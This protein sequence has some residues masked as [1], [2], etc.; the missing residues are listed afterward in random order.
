MKQKERTYHFIAIGLLILLLLCF[1]TDNQ[2]SKAQTREIIDSLHAELDKPLH[3][4]SRVI[5]LNRLAYFYRNTEPEKTKAFA[6]RAL[7]LSRD[8][9]FISGIGESYRMLGLYYK[10][11][12]N[13][14]KGLEYYLKAISEFEKANDKKGLAEALNNIGNI[15]K[16][17][18]NYPKALDYFNRSLDI[19]VELQDMRGIGIS[20]NNLGI[21]AVLQNDLD[22]AM[23][24]YQKSLNIFKKLK[25]KYRIGRLTYFIGEIYLKQKNYKKALEYF[26]NALKIRQEVND[27]NGIAVCYNRIGLI[28]L[29]T[30]EYEKAGKMLYLSHKLA[31]EIQARQIQVENY[32][33]LSKLDSAKGDFASALQYYKRYNALKDS[34]YS[35]E[36]KREIDRIEAQH[37]IEKRDNEIELQKENL[38]SQKLQQRYLIIGILLVF[39]LL[40]IAVLGYRQKKKANQ[41][42][43]DKNEEINQQKEEIRAQAEHL[44]EANE[45]ITAQNTEIT[46]QKEEILVQTERLRNINEELET[47]S[48]VVSKTDN[49]VLITDN[50]GKIEW[51]NDSFTKLFGY[52]LEQLVTEKN[53]NIINQNTPQYVKEKIQY[54]I[55]HKKMVQYELNV[56]TKEGEDLWVQVTLTPIYEGDQLEKLVAID[57][58]ITKLKQAEARNQKQ[59]E[60]IEQQRD[61]LVKQ[62]DKYEKQKR[63]AIR[64]RDELIQQRNEILDSIVYARRIQQAVL[65]PEEIFS[66]IFTES[67]ILYKPRDIVSGDFYWITQKEN[68]VVIA[69]ADCTGH[70]VPGAFMSI[71]AISFLNEIITKERVLKASLILNQLRDN[72][73]K[74]LRQKGLEREPKDGLDIALCII[75]T[76]TLEV[77]YAGANSPLFIVRPTDENY[78]KNQAEAIFKNYKNIS[79]AQYRINRFSN[80]HLL[81]VKADRMPI[82]I[83]IKEKKSFTN[84]ELQLQ[85]N[86]IIYLF[87]DGYIDQFGGREGRKFMKKRFK[88]LLVDLHRKPFEKQKDI[89]DNT[90]EEW[91]GFEYKQLDDMLVMGVKI[92]FKEELAGAKKKYYWKN[93]VFLIAEDME[94]TYMII[95]EVLSDTDVDLVWVENGKDAVDYCMENPVDLVLMDIHM[96]VMNGLDA[97]MELKKQ[98]PEIP[99]IV[100]TTDVMTNEKEKAFT[101][102]CD[103]YITKPINHKEL[104]A[105]ISKYV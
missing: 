1:L 12:G 19:K 2:Q 47:L 6:E 29:N 18:E 13:Y 79:N 81:Q 92:D 53:D 17:Q 44:K 43:L 58:D 62:S 20:Y 56:P 36:V 37:E 75:N 11:K 3:D 55:R 94:S 64:Q 8:L 21:I 4:T 41:L 96:P 71:L 5:V 76:E 65:P 52:T 25:N 99:I 85:K 54:C 69:G 22:N 46:Q 24:Y 103:D 15:Y 30:E 50:E 35:N 31:I 77:Q 63:M 59:R 95:E 90:I 67:F 10:V 70:G 74:S 60:E 9:R 61:E 57:T 33:A 7:I 100:E 72:I 27:K 23:Q 39:A 89:L 86:D 49:A 45:A 73:K 97:I 28:Y 14:E 42:L 32:L 98:K 48:V 104:L 80:C 88:Q 38:K 101:A 26:S 68:H 16:R 78:G 51:V 83:H 34:V 102:G 82:G 105:T 40:V 66:Q 84:H 93:K 91:Q 87:S